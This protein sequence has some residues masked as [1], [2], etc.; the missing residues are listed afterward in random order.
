MRAFASALA[1]SLALAACAAPPPDEAPARDPARPQ[2]VVS[3][4]LCT[5]ELVLLLAEPGQIASLSYLA[6][7]EAETPLWREGLRYPANDGTLTS[8]VVARPDL[9]LAM[10]G[11]AER[12]GVAARL[13]IRTVDLPFP[14]TIDDVVRSV[15]SVAA[16]LGRGQEGERLVR[17]I[18]A[19][20]RSAPTEPL[21]AWWIG[22]G[23][24][25]VA[26][27]GLESQWMALAGL[28]QRSG[29]GDRIELEDLL[30]HPPAILL[31]SDYR[32][33]EYSRAQAWL[34]HPL[35]QA[36]PGGR[37]LAADGRRWT[38]LGPLMIDE[39]ERLRREAAA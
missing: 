34:A 15:R 36:R 32:A 31:R 30:V 19:L 20:R 21:E 26:A 23:G 2:R 28:R 35:A 14:Q 5:D 3:L 6:Q 1:V 12:G 39:V 18:E 7:L 11:A 33:G 37:T 16:A 22:S 29:T 17:R 25:T 24:R 13:G 10:G 8:A 4:N 38:C 27:D 9:V